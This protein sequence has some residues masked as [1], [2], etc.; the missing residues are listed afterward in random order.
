MAFAK[1]FLKRNDN[2]T[3]ATLIAYDLQAGTYVQ[4]ARS[5]PEN[6]QRWCAQ[7]A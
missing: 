1:H 6:R 3:L 7:F 2:S 5:H 4:H